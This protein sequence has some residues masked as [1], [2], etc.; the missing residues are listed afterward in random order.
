LLDKWYERH[1]ASYSS[2]PQHDREYSDKNVTDDGSLCGII[3]AGLVIQ[4]Q[5]AMRL[6][7]GPQQWHDMH[8]EDFK[9]VSMIVFG[10]KWLLTLPMGLSAINTGTLADLS[11][12]TGFNMR[13]KITVSQDS[14]HAALLARL[15]KAGFNNTTPVFC[16]FFLSSVYD[17]QTSF[18]DHAF[19][20]VRVLKSLQK[21]Y[22]GP[23]VLV[24][25]PVIYTPGL[26]WNTY[27][28]KKIEWA[29]HATLLRT[30]GQFCNVPVLC[31]RIQT[32]NEDGETWVTR[33]RFWN[34]EP[35]FTKRG[36]LTCEYFTR[37]KDMLIE[38]SKACQE[39]TTVYI[40]F[41]FNYDITT[42]K[43]ELVT[44]RAIQ[45]KFLELKIWDKEE[46]KKEYFGSIDDAAKR[47]ITATTCLGQSLIMGTQDNAEVKPIEGCIYRYPTPSENSIKEG[48]RLL[49]AK[50]KAILPTWT[51]E[52][53]IADKAKRQLL[54]K[55]IFQY[56]SLAFD[57][58]K[59][60]CD[61]V[62][63]IDLLRGGTFPEHTVW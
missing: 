10:R 56:N 45:K 48:M 57:W 38:A 26:D 35:I 8:H 13:I 5:C 32:C 59:Q 54:E 1:V 6:N 49:N 21:Q 2:I 51:G 12:T 7:F 50:D 15:K 39:I 24:F 47:F 11:Y 28:A 22:K 30:M 60:M 37:I 29:K 3:H 44:I 58:E 52:E 36:E 33:N 61:M 20:F 62:S 63:D 42:V 9:S 46:V 34:N 23:I 40:L 18:E 25:T 41:E 19:G 4:E 31:L 14:L 55:F 53:F 27:N 16:E 43:T 17:S